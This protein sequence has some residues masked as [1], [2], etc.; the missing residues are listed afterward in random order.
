MK[1]PLLVLA[2]LVTRELGFQTGESEKEETDGLPNLAP[3]SPTSLTMV[4][5]EHLL[6]ADLGA[7]KEVIAQ[8]PQ[9]LNGERCVEMEGSLVVHTAGIMH[10]DHRAYLKARRM[11]AGMPG[12]VV[13]GQ[14]SL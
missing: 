10:W 9:S 6:G 14:K 4:I 7:R 1:G 5:S 11:Q 3:L 2:L 12:A 13:R 8:E